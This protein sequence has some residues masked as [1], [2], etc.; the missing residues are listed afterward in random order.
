VLSYGFWKDNFGGDPSVIGKQIRLSNGVVT[1]VGVAPQKF[2][3][4]SPGSETKL[5][6]PFQFHVVLNGKDEI[7]PPNSLWWCNTIS[8][9]KPRRESSDK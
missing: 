3:G 7:N 8:R 2:R 9:L 5:Y 4:V 6:L 1:V